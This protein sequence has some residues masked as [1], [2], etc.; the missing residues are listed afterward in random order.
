[1][2]NSFNVFLNGLLELY[3]TTALVQLEKKYLVYLTEV[4]FLSCYSK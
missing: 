4:N 3:T 2:A 1:M